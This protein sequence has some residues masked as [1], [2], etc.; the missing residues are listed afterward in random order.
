MRRLPQVARADGNGAKKHTTMMRPAV[1]ALSFLETKFRAS[2]ASLFAELVQ[3]VRGPGAEELEENSTG[4][5][6]RVSTEDN[7]LTSPVRIGQQSTAPSETDSP[8]C[9]RTVG[10]SATSEGSS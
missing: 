8:V 1:A 2:R 3:R 6:P 10:L 9:E 5:R 4:T 7:A